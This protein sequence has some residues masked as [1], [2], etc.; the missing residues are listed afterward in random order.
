[1]AGIPLVVMKIT[2]NM[3]FIVKKTL[4]IL[5]TI[6]VISSVFFT[7]PT[8]AVETTTVKAKV[9]EVEIKEESD[10]R[11]VAKIKVLLLEGTYG[12]TA[13]YADY[14][15]DTKLQVGDEIYVNQFV[16]ESEIQKVEYVGFNRSVYLLWLSVAALITLITIIGIKSPKELLPIILLGGVLVLKLFN[17]AFARMDHYLAAMIIIAVIIILV[18]V[19]KRGLHILNLIATIGSIASIG[20]TLMLQMF[21]SNAM[22][23]PAAGRSLFDIGVMIA[24]SG[25]IF[26][27]A[28]KILFE[29]EERLKL[30][31]NPNRNKILREGMD[32]SIKYSGFT[33]TA[34]FWAFVG[35]FFP[36]I[37]MAKESSS[38]IGFFNDPK[39]A[40]ITTAVL[41]SIIG[42]LIVP[43]ITTV[44]S[45]FIVDVN[46]LSRRAPKRKQIEMEV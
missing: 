38:Y 1:M 33:A 46:N 10:S 24:A 16:N 31:E 41:S 45:F 42:V 32:I 18:N 26:Y 44:L 29:L 28:Q 37:Y 7:K 35:L 5:L 8:F 11:V 39:I 40:Q 30:T 21:F 2:N 17:F 9:E 19:I 36:T 34:L 14:E 15:G 20:L 43:I 25:M 12:G 22:R 6:F 4:S 27:N 3:N 23:L 13:L